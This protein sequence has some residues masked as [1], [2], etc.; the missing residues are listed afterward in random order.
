MSKAERRILKL[1]AAQQL[2]STFIVTHQDANN[3]DLYHT[4]PNGQDFTRAELD[5]LPDNCTLIVIYRGN[6]STIP[7]RA[8]IGIP[9]NGRD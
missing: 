6:Q 3:P 5:A 8:V 1:E 2:K 9:Y 4:R 7:P